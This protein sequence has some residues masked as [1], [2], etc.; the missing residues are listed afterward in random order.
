MFAKN[1]YALVAGFREYAL[2][3]ETKGFDAKAIAG[4]IIAELDGGDARQVRLLYT[5]YDIENLVNLHNGSTAFNALGNLTREQTEEEY[6]RPKHLPARIAKVLRAYA[7]PEGEDA[8]DIDTTL[9]FGKNLFEAY[10]AECA[11]AGGHFLREWSLFDRTLRNILAATVARMEGR[12]T[13]SVVVGDDDTAEQLKRSS[14]ADFGL[15]GELE[16][17]DAV[18]AAVYDER[19]LLEKE[20]KIDVVRW[21]QADELSTFDYFNIDAVL[22]YLVKINIVARWSLLDPARGRELFKTLLAQL[23]GREA[24]AAGKY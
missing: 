14:A 12:P 21:S 4:E 10:Y 17:V 1:Y 13:E 15:R 18:I 8:E 3:A 22:A 9:P 11:E 5:C 7:D 6:S 24:V 23:D 19:D 16:Y 2:D 20:H